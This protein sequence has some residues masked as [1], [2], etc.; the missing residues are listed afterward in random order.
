[1]NNRLINLYNESTYCLIFLLNLTQNYERISK[2]TSINKINKRFENG[3]LQLQFNQMKKR[4][5]TK[6]S[7]HYKSYNNS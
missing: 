4:N 7:K 1:M 6:A 3:D 2:I 5:R